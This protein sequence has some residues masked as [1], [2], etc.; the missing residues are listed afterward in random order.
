MEIGPQ[1]DE[2]VVVEGV[3]RALL[4]VP[5][6]GVAA[7]R[8]HA[9]VAA[10]VD[11]AVLA[12]PRV[13]R[14]EDLVERVVE[15]VDVVADHEVLDEDVRP[16]E[17]PLG[18]RVTEEVV[19]ADHAD[20]V[21]R[22]VLRPAPV[23]LL[24]EL[25]LESFASRS[26]SS[27]TVPAVTPQSRRLPSHGFFFFGP[28]LLDRGD[29]R[30]VAGRPGA[31]AGRELVRG[32]GRRRVPERLRVDVDPRASCSSCRSSDSGSSPARSGL[33]KKSIRVT[34]R[35]RRFAVPSSRSAFAVSPRPGRSR[36]RRRGSRPAGRA[37]SR[38]R[39]AELHA[40]REVPLGHD[41]RGRL[42][43]ELD[44]LR[45]DLDVGHA[46]GLEGPDRPVDEP[47]SAVGSG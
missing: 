3:D 44:R 23:D 10:V 43:D 27:R 45:L 8:L 9:A 38:Q 6:E 33:T 21:D 32:V 7:A 5:A 42:D 37:G 22:E 41:D 13:V 30:R 2:E 24:E 1:V 4:A 47:A 26:V 14:V 39:L 15:D 28:D 31:S 29:V 18:A 11:E 40:D 17:E 35:S 36:S 46:L 19:G 34:P 16:V 25:R 12:G 20:V